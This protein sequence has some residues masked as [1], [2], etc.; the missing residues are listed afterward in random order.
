MPTTV[1]YSL[2]LQNNQDR[3]STPIR[4]TET[5]Q[6]SCPLSGTESLRNKTEANEE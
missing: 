3:C 2:Q 1:F 6:S 4:A 5:F